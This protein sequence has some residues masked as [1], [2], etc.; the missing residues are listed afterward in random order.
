MNLSLGLLAILF[1]TKGEFNLSCWLIVIAALTD[2]FDGIVARKLNIVSDIGKYLDSNSDLVSFGIAPAFLLYYS[3]L[4]EFG[5]WGI[6]VSFVFIFCGTY[7]LARYNSLKFD[8]YY[9]G[10]PI[11]IAGAILAIS[12]FV[13]DYIPAYFFVGI[14][15]ILSYSMVCTLKIKKM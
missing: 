1:T 14:T 4:Q 5:I 8:G 13:K 9:V 3:I 11:T 2:R 7:R 10:L 12:F 15:L 6:L